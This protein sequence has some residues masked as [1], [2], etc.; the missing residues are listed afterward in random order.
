[1]L[2]KCSLNFFFKKLQ[3]IHVQIEFIMCNKGDLVTHY[4]LQLSHFGSGD[5]IVTYSE[6]GTLDRLKQLIQIIITIQ[7][8]TISHHIMFK[9]KKK[10]NPKQTLILTNSNWKRFAQVG[11]TN[12]AGKSLVLGST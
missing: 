6:L 2:H 12:T 7:T 8:S 11:R 3:L 5:N 10:Q 9:N 4:Q 1:M